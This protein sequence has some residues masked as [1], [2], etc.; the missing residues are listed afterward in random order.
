MNAKR[1]AKVGFAAAAVGAGAYVLFSRRLTPSRQ[2][3]AA[4][5][6]EKVSARK[7]GTSNDPS[8]R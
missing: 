6:R 5:L 1:A 7:A 4:F 2:K 3:W 8:I